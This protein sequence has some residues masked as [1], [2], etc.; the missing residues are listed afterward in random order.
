MHIVGLDPSLTAAG[1]AILSHPKNADSPNIPKLNTVGVSGSESATLAER[2]IRI[3]DQR[4]RIIRSM[5]P[6]VCL[7]VIEALPFSAPKFAGLYQERCALYYALVEF[8]ARRKIP[9]VEVSATTLKK[10]ATGDGR[11]DKREVVN[12]MRDLWPHARVRNDNEADALALATMGAM[13]LGWHEPEMVHHF[14][15]NVNWTGVKR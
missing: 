6:S 5:P 9:V 15:P 4:D 13:R 14:S 12:A 1:V 2:S 7:V 11:A 8:L 10:Y 3:V